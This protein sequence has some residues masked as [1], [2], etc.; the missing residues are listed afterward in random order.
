MCMCARPYLVWAVNGDANSLNLLATAAVTVASRP[1]V[2]RSVV[3]QRMVYSVC[4]CVRVRLYVHLG[5]GH[6]RPLSHGR[7]SAYAEV[8]LRTARVKRC[9]APSALATVYC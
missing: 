1:S 2:G 7:R 5:V 8:Q 4:V 3:G 6:F 9:A